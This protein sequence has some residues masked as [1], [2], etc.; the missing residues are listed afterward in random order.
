MCVFIF[1]KKK[2]QKSFSS[3]KSS[4]SS[5]PTLFESDAQDASNPRRRSRGMFLSNGGDLDF[6]DKVV[7]EGGNDEEEMEHALESQNL[8]EH[9]YKRKNKK[10]KKTVHFEQDKHHHHPHQ[11]QM[12]GNMKMAGQGDASGIMALNYFPKKK[13]QTFEHDIFN[14]TLD[15]K[16][17]PGWYQMSWSKKYTQS[18]ANVSDFPQLELNS[19]LTALESSTG[20]RVLFAVDDLVSRSSKGR[21]KRGFVSLATFKAKLR[22]VG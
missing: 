20:K 15:R 6:L 7:H 17:E 10:K 16:S 3:S 4:I 18:H 2:M 22:I 19:K 13:N 21:S 11:P 14:I 1:Q 5:L 12:P 9:H 8:D